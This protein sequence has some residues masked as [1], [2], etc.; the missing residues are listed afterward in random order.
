MKPYV[1]LLESHVRSLI[2]D[3]R[4]RKRQQGLLLSTAY[5]CHKKLVD[6]SILPLFLQEIFHK[7]FSGLNMNPLLFPSPYYGTCVACALYFALTSRL[8]SCVSTM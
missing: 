7:T 5:C 3:V 4:R 2:E 1:D 8:L 6:L